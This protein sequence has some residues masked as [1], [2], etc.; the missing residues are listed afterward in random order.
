[1][2]AAPA[3]LHLM[4]SLAAELRVRLLHPTK[5]MSFRVGDVFPPEERP[6]ALVRLLLATRQLMALLH[7]SI[8]AS[9]SS[10][11]EKERLLFLLLST[12]AAAKES[13]DA[14]R[15]ADNLRCFAGLDEIGTSEPNHVNEALARLRTDGSKVSDDSLYSLILKQI[16][17]RASWHWSRNGVRDGLIALSDER[18]DQFLG[19]DRGWDQSLPLARD[20]VLSLTP[21]PALTP[22]LISGVLTWITDYQADL[23]T[24]SHSL[25]HA[26]VE[27]A[28]ESS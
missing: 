3:A 5:N 17:D 9:R 25:Y 4:N 12:I 15:D 13:T 14:F 28:E 7:A 23:V 10:P 16:R 1:M 26:L 2:E 6:V 11:G 21:L 22:E 18:Y 27:S 19:S 8:H 24:V 20:L